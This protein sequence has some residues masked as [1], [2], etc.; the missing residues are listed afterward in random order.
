[1]EAGDAVRL[2]ELRVL[3]GPNLYFTRPAIKVTLAVPGWLEGRWRRVAVPELTP[4]TV[5]AARRRRGLPSAPAR[6]LADVLRGV[7][8]EQGP[9][10]PGLHLTS[11]RE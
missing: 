1:M 2:V 10:Q 6:A 3:D 11:E 7:V 9:G 8:D 4:R 5:G